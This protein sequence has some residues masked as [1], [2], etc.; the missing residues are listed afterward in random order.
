TRVGQGAQPPVSG[1]SSPPSHAAWGPALASADGV[2]VALRGAPIFAS[3]RASGAESAAST[4]LALY[5]RAGPRALESISGRFALAV[6]DGPGKRALLAVDRMGIER[7]TYALGAS[8]LVFGSSAEDVARCPTIGASINRQSLFDYLL[9]HMVPAPN[10]VFSGVSKLRAGTCAVFENGKLSVQRYWNPQFRESSPESF[11]TLKAGLHSSLRAGVREAAPDERSGAFLSGGLDSSSVA[12]VLS[13]VAPP[14]K[15]FSIGF[16]YP[17]YDERSYARIAN[18]RFKCQGHEYVVQGTDIA[19]TFPRIARAYDEPFGNSSALPVYYCARLARE[20]GVDHLLAG[21]GGDELFAGN[22][23]YAEH[24]VFERYQTFPKFARVGLLEP[25]LALWPDALM[26]PLV[27][28]A[29]GYVAKANTPLPSRLEAY[30]IIN[31]SGAAQFLHP[32]FLAAI[33][34][35]APFRQMHE[36]WDSAKSDNTVQR[37]LFYDWQYTLSDNDLRKV[38]SMT[39]LAGVRV[40]YPMLHPDV[41][42]LSLRVPPRVMMEDMRLRDFYK[43]AMQGWLPDQIINKKKH[44]FGLPFGLWLQDSPQLRELIFANLASLRARRLIRPE[45]IDRLMQLHGQE[46][47]SFYGVFVWVLAMLEQWFQEH[48]HA[49]FIAA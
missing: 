3:P 18:E 36:V 45:F 17:Q 22:S 34:P 42:D 23:R 19:D 13:E 20:N 32:D 44:G 11:E 48:G 38:E 31:Q 43:K 33:D 47:A 49:K 35:A 7:M 27:R 9:L 24:Q 39:A 29:R 46:D 4:L 12:G 28:K 14:A 8:C 15:T 5:R 37:M 21:D 26:N 1:S 10:T 41:I 16:S 6:I 40:S 25:L 2:T 30:N